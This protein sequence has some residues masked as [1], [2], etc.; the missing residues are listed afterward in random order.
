VPNDA[1]RVARGK[2]V[3]DAT[4]EQIKSVIDRGGIDDETHATLIAVHSGFNDSTA[5]PGLRADSVGAPETYA[6]AMSRGKPWP[7]AIDKE[8]GNHDSFSSFNKL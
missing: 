7:A 5:Q 2:L 4:A 3:F 8:F 6:E 1:V